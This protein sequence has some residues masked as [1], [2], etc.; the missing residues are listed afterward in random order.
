MMDRA[1]LVRALES[2]VENAVHH[3]PPG[4]EVVVRT[5]PDGHDGAGGAGGVEIRIEDSGD[6]FRADDLPRVFEPFFTR[7]SGGTGLGLAIAERIVV[8]HGGSINAGNRDGDGSGGIMTV[9]LPRLAH[10]DRPT[11]RRAENE[12]IST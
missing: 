12:E 4:R 9:R 6:G 3:S 11:D 5:G 10:D 1:G 7:R 2:L 8:D